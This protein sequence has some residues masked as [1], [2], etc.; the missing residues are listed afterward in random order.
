MPVPTEMNTTTRCVAVLSTTETQGADCTLPCAVH[1]LRRTATSVQ[2]KVEKSP[3]QT[4]KLPPILGA[5]RRMAC[6]AHTPKSSP[7]WS[8]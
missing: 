8:T 5:S 1:T 4:A 7:C 2:S 3:P 6:T